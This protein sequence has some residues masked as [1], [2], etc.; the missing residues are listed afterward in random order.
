MNAISFSLNSGWFALFLLATVLWIVTLLHDSITTHNNTEYGRVV[1][2][3]MQE[4][5]MFKHKAER[6]EEMCRQNGLLSAEPWAMPL[7]GHAPKSTPIPHAQ[8]A[9]E[10][11]QASRSS[12]PSRPL[13]PSRWGEE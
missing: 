13:Q 4:M 1:R 2:G 10:R 6:L 11:I 9:I 5:F 8:H 7:P 3:V 12:M